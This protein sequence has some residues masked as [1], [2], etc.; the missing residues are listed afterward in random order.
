LLADP[1][2]FVMERRM[3]LGIKDRAEQRATGVRPLG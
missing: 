3:L 2:T 1:I